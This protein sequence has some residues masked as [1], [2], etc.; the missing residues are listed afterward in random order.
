MCELELR[1]RLTSESN[2]LVYTFFAAPELN[3]FFDDER[4]HVTPVGKP[5]MKFTN[6]LVDVFNIPEK[7][8]S[9]FEEKKRQA[10]DW[11]INQINSSALTP[12]LF[13]YKPEID[14]LTI[15]VTSRGQSYTLIITRSVFEKPNPVYGTDSKIDVALYG[16]VKE[17]NRE[18]VF[19]LESKFSEYLKPESDTNRSSKYWDGESDGN[20]GAFQIVHRH[21]EGMRLMKDMIIGK[22]KDTNL[23]YVKSCNGSHYCQ[24]ISQMIAHNHGALNSEE[25]ANGVQ[26]FLGSVL[27]DFDKGSQNLSVSKE[28]RKECTDLLDDYKTVYKELAVVLNDIDRSYDVNVIDEVI[29]HQD[30]LKDY[31]LDTEVKEFYSI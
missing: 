5:S 11:R 23:S 16:K 24:G 15:T 8:R 19:F 21:A 25:L 14:N 22:D 12:L 20:D 17:T 9:L 13:F 4:H 28:Y 1:N 27:F 10:K 7:N 29:T 3:S 26:V 2:R 30:L 31:N 6:S 18:C